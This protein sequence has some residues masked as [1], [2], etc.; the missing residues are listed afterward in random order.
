MSANPS[1]NNSLKFWIQTPPL[2]YRLK[3]FGVCVII[4]VSV[5]CNWGQ[6]QILCWF[7]YYLSHSEGFNMLFVLMYNVLFI[8]LLYLL[9]F[10]PILQ[11]CLHYASL[12]YRALSCNGFDYSQTTCTFYVSLCLSLFQIVDLDL[13]NTTE[14]YRLYCMVCSFSFFCMQLKLFFYGFNNDL[15][16]YRELLLVTSRSLF[17]EFQ[18][19][20]LMVYNCCNCNTYLAVIFGVIS[21]V[22]SIF[23]WFLLCVPWMQHK[24][25]FFHSLTGFKPFSFI[26][27]PVM[28]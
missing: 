22:N 3:M 14:S 6:S 10:T 1:K 13:P 11:K 5:L 27:F 9:I 26:T 8:W 4:L 19:L 20:L 2:L 23:L 21:I 17:A 25:Y 28:L 7:S 24:L 12:Q 18:T 15:L 16:Y